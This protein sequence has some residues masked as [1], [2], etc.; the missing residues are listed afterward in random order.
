MKIEKESEEEQ[1]RGVRAQAK[2]ISEKILKQALSNVSE[3]E[4]TEYLWVCKAVQKEKSFARRVEL[5]NGTIKHIT[6]WYEKCIEKEFKKEVDVFYVRIVYF[7]YCIQFEPKYVLDTVER[8]MV[9][10][11]MKYLVFAHLTDTC[12]ER[13]IIKIFTEFIYTESLKIVI[14]WKEYRYITSKKM[15][16]LKKHLHSLFGRPLESSQALQ[17]YLKEKQMFF[18]LDNLLK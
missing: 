17:D 11:E 12:L 1:A 6:A 10:I 9:E 13:D 5:L 7:L 8:S 18:L 15:Q 2:R 16:S 4:S 3:E 14:S